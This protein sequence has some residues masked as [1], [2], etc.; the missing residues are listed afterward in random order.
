[1]CKWND[2]RT[3]L[4][5]LKNF[6]SF[7]LLLW[8]TVYTFFFL[9]TPSTFAF[10]FFSPL[11]AETV[12]LVLLYLPKCFIMAIMVP[13]VSTTWQ[14]RISLVCSSFDD[15]TRC[16][17]ITP[18]IGPACFWYNTPSFSHLSPQFMHSQ[19][20]NSKNEQQQVRFMWRAVPGLDKLPTTTKNG[21][22]PPPSKRCTMFQ[23]LQHH[24]DIKAVL[25]MYNCVHNNNATTNQ[26]GYMD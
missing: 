25:H 9:L 19:F 5:N 23:R 3:L 6:K 7:P 14:A 10:F 15:T 26:V 22:W 12:R 8:S 16:I 4:Y 11:S 1:M 18:A 21:T 17:F 13:R 24:S 2:R 20:E